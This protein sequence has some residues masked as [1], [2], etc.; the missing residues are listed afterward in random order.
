LLKT[1]SV[2]LSMARKAPGWTRIWIEPLGSLWGSVPSWLDNVLLSV[3][4][5][6]GLGTDQIPFVRSRLWRKNTLFSRQTYEA[7]TRQRV[8]RHSRYPHRLVRL[9]KGGRVGHT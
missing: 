7:M 8:R 9:R 1:I 3:V 5:I 6:Q 2:G 4:C